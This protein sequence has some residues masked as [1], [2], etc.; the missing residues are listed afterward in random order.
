MDPGGRSCQHFT[1]LVH[2][3]SYLRCLLWR[4]L[5]RSV[6]QLMC[7][8]CKH[9]QLWFES[10]LGFYFLFSLFLL[11]QMIPC[12]SKTQRGRFHKTSRPPSSAAGKAADDSAVT[13]GLPGFG[14][15]P[16]KE[17]TKEKTDTFSKR[18]QQA[19]EQL[20]HWAVENDC[21]ATLSWQCHVCFLSDVLWK[22]CISKS[23]KKNGLTKL[24]ASRAPFNNSNI[25]EY[26]NI[27]WH[28]R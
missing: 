11:Q 12:G 19:G 8:Q 21:P 9:S 17:Q 13:K 26:I 20:W 2:D 27:M 10:F 25:T 16:Q 3:A 14:G 23:L 22:G 4:L 15:H 7:W 5:L 28:S 1:I 6:P 18:L 24:S